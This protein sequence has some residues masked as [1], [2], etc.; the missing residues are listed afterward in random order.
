MKLLI[1]ILRNLM[2]SQLSDRDRLLLRV[3]G[4]IIPGTKKYEGG[5]YGNGYQNDF[6]ILK[7]VESYRKIDN[8]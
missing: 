7:V 8:K 5:V 3:R 4:E 2:A 1:E 6:V